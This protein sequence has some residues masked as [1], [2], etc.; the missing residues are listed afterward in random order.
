LGTSRGIYH[1]VIVTTTNRAM[2][3]SHE[4]KVYIFS[5]K[6]EQAKKLLTIHLLN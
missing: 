3:V 2:I 4:I 1:A 6:R 5:K